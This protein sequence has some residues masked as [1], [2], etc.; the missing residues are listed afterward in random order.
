MVAKFIHEYVVWVLG[1]LLSGNIFFAARVI[2]S[3]EES[4]K[5]VAVMQTQIRGFEGVQNGYA[6]L[7][8]ALG[9]LETQ[10]DI[11]ADEVRQKRK[12]D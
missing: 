8:I 3:V 6:D 9:K 1:A 5:A 12:A 4:S 2:A 7:R 11:L 10:V